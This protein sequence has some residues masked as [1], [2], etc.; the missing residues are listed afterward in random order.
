MWTTLDNTNCYREGITV[1]EVKLRVT[2]GYV[3]QAFLLIAVFWGLLARIFELAAYYIA[4]CVQ[5]VFGLP[6]YQLGVYKF[7]QHVGLLL[8]ITSNICSGC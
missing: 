7:G 2:P 5:W 4:S 1:H 3:L 6:M 8:L